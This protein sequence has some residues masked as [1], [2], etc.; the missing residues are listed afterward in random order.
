M[1]WHQ[2][3]NSILWISKVKKRRRNSVSKT[4]FTLSRQIIVDNI[5]HSLKF[6]YAK[7]VNDPISVG[8]AP[9]KVLLPTREEEK[10]KMT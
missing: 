6:R 7:N 5:F 10:P 3:K 9:V 4:L 8:I 1:E 2:L